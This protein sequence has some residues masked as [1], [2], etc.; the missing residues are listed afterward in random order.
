MSAAGP[1]LPGLVVAAVGSNKHHFTSEDAVLLVVVGILIAATGFLAM[2]ETALTRTS[3]VKALTL[4]EEKRRGATML[5]RLVQRIERVLPL[6]LF[7]VELCTL[8]AAT[9]VGVVAEH[10]FG[11]IGVLIATVFEVVV[12]FVLAELAPKTWAVQHTERAALA[13][14]PVVR[15]LVAFAPLGWITRALIAITNAILPGRGM[16]SGPYMSDE[17]LRAMAD[18]A[19]EEEVIE[20]EERTLI[21][22]IID[23]GDTVVRDVMVPR[24]DMV[25]VESYARISDVIDVVVPSGFSR[26]P[27]YSQGIDDI[28]GTVYVKDLMQAERVGHGDSQVSTVMRPAQFT[29]ES[30]RVAELMREMQ[31]GKFHMS[32]VVDE[33]GGTAGLVTLED[34]IEELVGEITDEYD[35]EESPPLRLD[36]GTLVVNARMPVDEVNELLEDDNRSLP[37][38]ED[39]DTIGGLLYSLLGHVPTEGESADVD[40]HRLVAERVQGRRI[41]RVRISALPS[42][43]S[44]DQETDEE[45]ERAERRS[46]NGTR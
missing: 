8:V 35:Q 13:A 30:K 36:D 21:H 12:I 42:S 29:P 23:F 34:L 17:M 7:A 19:A 26:I 2:A 31:A 39:W 9:L 22:S 10:A 32:I 16:R 38:G 4:V 5:L 43:R 15:L 20:H 41:G 44:S 14:A 3:K 25:A 28:V 37:E 33:F 1:G 40:G 24:P 46:E 27:V 11:G 18:E 6:V 45:G